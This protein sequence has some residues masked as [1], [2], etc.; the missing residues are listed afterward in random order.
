M[1]CDRNKMFEVMC[2]H[3]IIIGKNMLKYLGMTR[4]ELRKRMMFA[5]YQHRL[6]KEELKK[7]MINS[8]EVDTYEAIDPYY[9]KIEAVLCQKED[10][11]IEMI[12]K[13]LVRWKF[14]RLSY[15]DQAIL[16]LATAEMEVKENEDAIIINE[17]IELAKTFCDDVSF[18]YINGVLDNLWQA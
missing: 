10:A 6:L 2:F 7:M 18:K 9:Q 4:H 12:S 16:L 15:V 3:F 8:F 5:I 11:Y 13:H 1:S 14:G 17:A